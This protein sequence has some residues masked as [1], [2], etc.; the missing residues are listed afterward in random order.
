MYSSSEKKN[1]NILGSLKFYALSPQNTL[2]RVK[3]TRNRVKRRCTFRWHSKILH[4][5]V[6]ENKLNYILIY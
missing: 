1:E 6:L 2:K 5:I 4:N 3:L